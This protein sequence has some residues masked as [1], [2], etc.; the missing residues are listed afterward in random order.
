[1]NTNKFE[2]PSVTVD[3][4]VFT[5]DR[6]DLK[7]IL[8]KRGIEPFKNMWALPGGFVGIGETLEAAAKRELYQETGVEDV[9]LEQLYT[10]GDPKRDPRT[11]VITVSY[12]ALIPSENIK[13]HP[14]T[15]VSDAKWFSIK[16]LPKLAFDHEKILRY[17]VERLRS[18]VG[19]SNVVF[20]LLP[21]KFRL[22]ELQKVYEVIL[23]QNLDKRNFRKR[24]LSL[25]LL[26]ST[27]K[28]EV[29]GAHRPAMLYEFKSRE[30]VLFDFM[31]S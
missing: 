18:K 20:G 19:Y 30:V 6:D 28:K 23:G 2:K 1:M 10:F 17:G 14:T 27:G 16:K 31:I 15:D 25:G 9:Y 8:V 22:S 12:F 4:L 29:E 26:K 24:M 13:L 3:L 5:V 11:R 7:I 21:K